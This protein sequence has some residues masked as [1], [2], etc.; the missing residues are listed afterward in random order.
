[1]GITYFVFGLLL[2]FP[3]EIDTGQSG[4]YSCVQLRRGLTMKLLLSRQRYTVSNLRADHET[5]NVGVTLGMRR[6]A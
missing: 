3:V 6:G 4:I 5:D 2:R 1:M